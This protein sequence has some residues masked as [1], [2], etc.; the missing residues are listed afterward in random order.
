MFKEKEG[1]RQSLDSNTKGSCSPFGADESSYLSK[2]PAW[3]ILAAVHYVVHA[4]L[5]ACDNGRLSPRKL[6]MGKCSVLI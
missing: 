6:A 1:G 5:T 4:G 2:L 3:E